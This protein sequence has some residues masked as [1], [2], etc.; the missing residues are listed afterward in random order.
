MKHKHL[1]SEMLLSKRLKKLK[2]T[3]R[4]TAT[5]IRGLAVLSKFQAVTGPAQ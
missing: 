3:T 5:L 2:V 1:K 4:T